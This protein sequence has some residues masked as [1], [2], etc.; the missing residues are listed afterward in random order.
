MTRIAL[1]CTVLFLS[2]VFALPSVQAFSP[3]QMNPGAS[4]SVEQVSKK[5]DLQFK[6]CTAKCGKNDFICSTGCAVDRDW[7]NA[8]CPT[9]KQQC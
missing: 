5:C 2:A 8:I 7:C 1:V 6:K 9:G 3:A 4:S